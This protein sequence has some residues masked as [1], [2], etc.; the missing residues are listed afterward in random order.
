MLN[1]TRL[2]IWGDPIDHSRSPELHTAAYRVL[3]LDWQYERRRVAEA[4]FP[5]ALTSLGPEWRG[6]SLTMPLKATAHRHAIHLDRRAELTRAVNTYL[7]DV[8]GPRGFNTDVGGLARDL[9]E[10][11]F[12]GL[13]RARLVGA[14][15]TA[16]SALV[17]LAELGVTD[18]EVIA[19]R[20][21]A[22]VP[23][24]QL[25]TELGLVVR[26]SP[27]LADTYAAAPLTVAALPGAAELPED[28]AERLAAAGGAL[29]DV[30]YGHWP[31]ILGTAWQR[32]GLDAWDG[33]GM[34]LHQAV[35][36]VRVFVNGD[37]DAPLPE[38]DAVLA[39]MRIA[40]L[41]AVAADT[42]HDPGMG[43]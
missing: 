2:A 6:L 30:V 5:V 36:Q 14:G 25:G 43:D 24:Q 32:A 41:A 10:R 28:A 35:L 39:S 22:V 19:R 15:A 20:P 21:A 9:R 13:D 12:S 37:P 7:I 16:T 42:G 3:G 4:D 40:L 17:A 31:S 26:S 33:L 11:G 38:E 34:L 27:F 1:G 18:I 29:Y 8:D 23:L